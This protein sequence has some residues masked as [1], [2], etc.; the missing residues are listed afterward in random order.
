M[1]VQEQH[2]M[3]NNA[4]RNGAKAHVKLLKKAELDLEANV[5]VDTSTFR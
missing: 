2:K 5:W 3:S 4:V 1:I